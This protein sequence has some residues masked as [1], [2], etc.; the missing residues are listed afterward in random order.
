MH[1]R[2]WALRAPRGANCFWCA[3]RMMEE[4][5]R[6]LWVLGAAYATLAALGALFTIHGYT[7]IGALAVIPLLVISYYAPLWLAF[8]TGVVAGVAFAY[9]D[10]LPQHMRM[11]VFPTDAAVLGGSYVAVVIASELLRRRDAQRVLLEQRLR[12]A[13][14]VASRDTLTDMPNRR[15]FVDALRAAIANGRATGA[16]FAVLYCDLDGFKEIN[17]LHGHAIGDRT[18]AVA[19]KRLTHA[20]RP[21]DIVARIGGDEFGIIV[22]RIEDRSDVRRIQES[23]ERA[24]GEPLTIDRLRLAVG[25]TVGFALFPDSGTA[26]DALLNCADEAMYRRKRAK[27]IRLTTKGTTEG[28]RT[29]K[30]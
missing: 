25:I 4:S 11:F 27:K 8:A 18:L 12:Q 7:R 5:M 19:S 29:P 3:R 26:E 23:I 14:E 21:D 13:E 16:R 6:K 1:A 20:L 15:Y 24:F 28:A 17:D 22:R 9:L 30:P 10:Q 2:V